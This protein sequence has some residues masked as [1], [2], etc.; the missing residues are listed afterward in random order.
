MARVWHEFCEHYSSNPQWKRMKKEQNPSKRH[1]T[2]WHLTRQETK[3]RKCMKLSGGCVSRQKGLDGQMEHLHLGRKIPFMLKVQ[4]ASIFSVRILKKKKRTFRIVIVAFQGLVGLGMVKK[5]G[6]SCTQICH[7]LKEDKG[8][9][10]GI[11]RWSWSGVEEGS[12]I[13]EDEMIKWSYSLK[14]MEVVHSEQGKEPWT[15]LLG[16]R[17]IHVTC[18]PDRWRCLKCN[19]QHEFGK[20]PQWRAWFNI[21]LLP[22]SLLVLCADVCAHTRARLLME[23]RG[24]VPAR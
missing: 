18:E 7:H 14:S 12:G 4:M 5:L 21:R 9:S 2:E 23:G 15:M 22:E 20:N 19:V 6:C 13:R 3:S 16:R 24:Y 10:F 8:R 11:E 17:W 1:V